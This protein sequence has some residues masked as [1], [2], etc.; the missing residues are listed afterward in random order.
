VR[1]TSDGKRSRRKAQRW[2]HEEGRCSKASMGD[3]VAMKAPLSNVPAA[4]AN[5]KQKS[6]EQLQWGAQCGFDE[7]RGRI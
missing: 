7:A 3:G 2:L 5:R 1:I 6:E 4:Q